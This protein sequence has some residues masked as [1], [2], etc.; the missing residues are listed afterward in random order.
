M[1]VGV[2]RGVAGLY[3]WFCFSVCGGRDDCVYDDD[4]TIERFFF[5][6]AKGV[7]KRAARKTRMMKL[8]CSCGFTF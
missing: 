5:L 4:A 7:E 8:D 1:N 6:A 3:I 2:C